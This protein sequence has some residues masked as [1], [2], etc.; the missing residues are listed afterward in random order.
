ML[1]G[2]DPVAARFMR[3]DFFEF[4]PQFKFALSA[5]TQNRQADHEA[6][7]LATTIITVVVPG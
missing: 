3:H 1:A 2:G 6:K 4:L 5:F 7:Y